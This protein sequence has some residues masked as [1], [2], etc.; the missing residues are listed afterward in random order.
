[1]RSDEASV[2]TK[3]GVLSGIVSPAGVRARSPVSR[4]AIMK[5]RSDE[6]KPIDGVV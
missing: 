2:Q 3:L 5:E 6:L 4:M 1:M